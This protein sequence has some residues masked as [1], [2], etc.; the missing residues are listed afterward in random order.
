MFLVSLTIFLCIAFLFFYLLYLVSFDESD[1]FNDESDNDGSD[2][3]SAGTG[4]FPFR[5]D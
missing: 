1:F 5:F 3:G 2:S 4:V